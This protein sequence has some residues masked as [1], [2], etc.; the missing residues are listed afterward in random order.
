ML[1]EE[2]NTVQ[3]SACALMPKLMRQCTKLELEEITN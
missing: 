3:N 1:T 2:A